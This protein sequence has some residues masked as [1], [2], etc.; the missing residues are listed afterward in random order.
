[1][2]DEEVDEILLANAK[3]ELEAEMILIAIARAEGIE[4]SDEEFDAGVLR[5]LNQLDFVDEADFYDR[6][7][8]SFVDAYGRETILFALTYEKIME[9]VKETMVEVE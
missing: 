6:A 5:F 2:T 7:G 3:Q 4:F 8:M 9:I 1:M